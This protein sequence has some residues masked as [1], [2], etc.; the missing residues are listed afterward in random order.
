MCVFDA[1]LSN[2]SLT[3]FFSFGWLY[4]SKIDCYWIDIYETMVVMINARALALGSAYVCLSFIHFSNAACICKVLS[5]SLSLRFL[6]IH[7][8]IPSPPDTDPH[9]H[10]PTQPPTLR[11]CVC[12]CVH[13]YP[14]PPYSIHL[15]F[16]ISVSPVVWLAPVATEAAVALAEALAASK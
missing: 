7:P 4:K 10:K 15:V 16:L 9:I 8:F 6:L 5:H 3:L 1:H 12:V 11:V 13:I 14:C 2:R